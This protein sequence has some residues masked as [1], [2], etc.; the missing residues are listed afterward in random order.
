MG[1]DLGKSSGLV[2]LFLHGGG[3]MMG[4]GMESFL[5]LSK[6]ITQ[7]Y[8]FSVF[9]TTII[10]LLFASYTRFVNIPSGTRL[11]RHLKFKQDIQAQQHSL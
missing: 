8:R 4:N 5:E 2:G 6:F 1:G 9:P 10:Q 3:Y 11:R 7:L